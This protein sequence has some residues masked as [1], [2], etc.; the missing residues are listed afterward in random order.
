LNAQ[1]T[2]PR[3][4]RWPEYFHAEATILPQALFRRYTK[5]L[6]LLFQA[7]RLHVI[8]DDDRDIIHERC[9]MPG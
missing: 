1:A 7:F 5:A 8:F 3:N 6:L 2:A 9:S 4:T